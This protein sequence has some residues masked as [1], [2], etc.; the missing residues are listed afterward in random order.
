MPEG[1]EKKQKD[2]LE[3]KEVL[4]R[5]LITG[6]KQVT[7]NLIQQEFGRPYHRNLDRMPFEQH[8]LTYFNRFTM[9][10]VWRIDKREQR[11]TLGR[12]C[13]N[14]ERNG[15]LEWTEAVEKV[16]SDLNLYI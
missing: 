12:L 3:Q 14:I 6:V 7:W 9:A 8:S 15:N 4:R 13:N 16:K 1:Y 10:T 11:K 2:L 5:M